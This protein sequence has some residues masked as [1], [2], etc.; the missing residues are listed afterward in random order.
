MKF[1]VSI[2]LVA[3]LAAVCGAL[4]QNPPRVPEPDDPKDVA[5]I[6]ASGGVGL[7]RDRDGNVS[8]LKVGWEPDPDVLAHIARL[9]HV[10]SIKVDSDKDADHWLIPTAEVPVT[11]L[12]RDEILDDARLPIQ[13][14]AY[15]PCFRAEAGAAG[16][17]PWP[18]FF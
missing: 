8:G 6:E 3:L 18:C 10:R 5:A 4:P 17:P 2:A 11:N 13:L 15:T 7:S 14:T 12:Y 9:R 16:N 1:L